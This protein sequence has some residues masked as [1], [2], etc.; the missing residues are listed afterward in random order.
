[1]FRRQASSGHQ[2][3]VKTFKSSAAESRQATPTPQPR[4]TWLHDGVMGGCIVDAARP[5]GKR[6]LTRE[7]YAPIRE[8]TPSASGARQCGVAFAWSRRA[9]V[10]RP[11][12]QSAHI[13][14]NQ[15]VYSG[16]TLPRVRSM[17]IP[18]AQHTFACATHMRACAR[19]STHTNTHARTHVRTHTQTRTFCS[20]HK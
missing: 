13:S 17:Y 3:P 6:L 14:M 8:T 9:V 12:A 2:I 10:V 5:F 15:M 18:Q 20:T 11:R 19:A 4:G 7:L 16:F 1:M